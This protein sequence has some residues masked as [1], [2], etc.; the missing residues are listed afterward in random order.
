ML[1]YSAHTIFSL[2]F[3]GVFMVRARRASDA[4]KYAIPALVPEADVTG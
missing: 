3:M 4:A 1:A 2:I